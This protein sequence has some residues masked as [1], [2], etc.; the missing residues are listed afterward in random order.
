MTQVHY[1]IFRQVGRDGSW[2]LM[3]AIE[4]R[5]AAI[6]RARLIL[7]EGRAAAV[8]VVKETLLS[9]SSDYVSLVVL[10]E[11]NVQVKKKN[12]KVEDLDSPVP[13]FKPDD[14]YSYHARQTLLRLVGDWLGRQRMT[15]TELLHSAS[16]L[17]KFEATGT[18]FQH[19]IQKVAVAQAADTN[20]PVS[21][22][23]KQLNELC[24]TA[25]HRVYKDE[26]R[27]LFPEIEGGKFG[28]LAEK[29]GGQP[30]GRY[31]LNGILAKHLAP[32]ANWDAKLKLL[33]NLM[34]ELPAEGPGRALLLACIDGMIAEMLNGQAAL[35][36]LLG[37]NPDLGHA[38]LNLVDLFLGAQVQLAEGAGGGINDLA[39]FFVKD[40][41][42]EA[43]NAIATRIL[44]EL[45][46]LKRLCPNSLDD[47][48]KMLRRLANQLVRGQGKYLSHE[49]LIGAFTDR[50]KRLVTHEPLL[51]FMASAKTPDEKIERLLIVEENIIGA[52]NKR[53]LS[54]FII[55]IISSN[56]FEDQLCA[57]A[58]VL[59]RL[60][61][62]AELQERVRR[63]GFQDVQKNQIT[64][65]LDGVAKRIEERA[66]FLASLEAKTANPVDRARTILKLCAS[67]AFTQGDVMTK[68]RRMIIAALSKPGFLAAYIAQLQ[69]ETKTEVD[70]N[71]ALDDLAGQLAGIGIA[72]E[73]AMRAL[74]A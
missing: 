61:R 48:F 50:S 68:A 3:E 27:G 65:A 12:K 64:A 8:R 21:Q 18:T 20:F 62:A 11:G 6:A 17:E 43:R 74:A 9:G 55:P 42:P 41:L 4:T 35:G 70:R 30:D 49:G 60:T 58:P 5:D 53:T 28:P 59:Q 16:A 66:K 26:K 67:K 7:E 51:Q 40:E 45:K 31:V 36:V 54:T 23:V 63:A 13:C 1:E 73:D 46:G 24:T 15:V 72:Q 39:R 2:A 47:E 22:I 10:E 33:L 19:A 69:A 44:S 14:L 57:G 29:L 56:N 34:A 37:Q 25:I 38:L 71:K 52:E 32:A